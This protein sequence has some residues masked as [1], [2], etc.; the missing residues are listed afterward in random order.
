MKIYE[1]HNIIGKT[2]VIALKTSFNDYDNLFDSL[3]IEDK[4]NFKTNVTISKGNKYE[5]IKD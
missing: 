5:V 1:N 2:G 4:T 3:D